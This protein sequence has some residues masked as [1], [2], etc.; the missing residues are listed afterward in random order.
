MPKKRLSSKMKQYQLVFFSV[1]ALMSGCASSIPNDYELHRWSG[2]IQGTNITIP[3]EEIKKDSD[4][5][6]YASVKDPQ[7]KYVDCMYYQGY[8]W[9]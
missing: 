1:A 9:N 7:V 6:K 8:R 2:R 5:C 4:V 3:P